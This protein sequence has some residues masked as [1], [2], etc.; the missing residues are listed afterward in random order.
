MYFSCRVGR[1][2]FFT[3]VNARDSAM[4]V[5]YSTT[6]M[7]KR[8][9]TSSCLRASG[10][11]SAAG[12]MGGAVSAAENTSTRAVPSTAGI[13]AIGSLEVGNRPA[14]LARSFGTHS[15]APPP[16]PP[17]PEGSKWSRGAP[18]IVGAALLFAGGFL[19][20]QLLAGAVPSSDSHSSIA[21]EDEE[22]EPA[23]PQAAISD[24]VF[25]DIEIDGAPAGRVIMGLYGGVVP[26][27]VEN[28]VGLC[29]GDPKRKRQPFGFKGS[30]FH[31]AIPGFMVQGGDFTRGDGTGGVSI[32]GGKFKDEDMS[33]LKHVGPGVLSM[34]NS[35][36]N[37]N[38]SQFFLTTAPCRWL[39][40]KHVVFG[41]VL[42]GMDVVFRIEEL[43]SRSG[44]LRSK[45]TIAGCG[46]VKRNSAAMETESGSWTGVDSGKDGFRANA[47]RGVRADV[48][49]EKAGVS[50]AV[51]SAL[52]SA[53]SGAAEDR[54]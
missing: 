48:R 7:F 17:P 52:K 9:S 24:K 30:S 13:K 19:G 8:A 44:K 42:Q 53:P 6:G 54:D 29:K 32:F 50:R 37:S 14:A 23:I 21:D 4:V 10:S 47:M 15:T 35:G 39:D 51:G 3:S 11:A 46:L 25:F 18:A 31:R 49:E 34:A 38:G 41:Q 20:A 40:G 45:A 12:G 26:K 22:P 1:R 28:F 36:P 43:G 2:L 33:Q 5:R 16:T 27:T